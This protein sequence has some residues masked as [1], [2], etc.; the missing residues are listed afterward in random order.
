MNVVKPDVTQAFDPSLLPVSVRPFV[1]RVLRSGEGYEAAIA[2][3]REHLD[4]GGER[5]PTVLL[6]LATLTYEDAAT[7]VLSQL[8]AASQAALSLVDEAMAK[9]AEPSEE[10]QSLRASFARALERE[11]IREQRLRQL[12]KDPKR[13]RPTELMELAH[14]IL[15]SGE[16]DDLA[17]ALMARAARGSEDP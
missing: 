1:E 16:D 17:A 6:A 9:D 12:L 13:A 14:R 10:L 4:G 3:L 5:T 2:S 8:T 7:L 15:M 11:R